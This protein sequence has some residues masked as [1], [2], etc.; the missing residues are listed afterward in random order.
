MAIPP[1]DTP[2]PRA[3]PAPAAK[4]PAANPAALS[5]TQKNAFDQVKAQ[6]DAYGL[7]SLS[8][9]VYNEIVAGKSSDEIARDLRG[10]PEFKARFPA[11][12]ARE[13]AGLPSLSPGEYVSYENQATQL[14]RAAG[15]P[16]GFYDQ[17]EDFTKLLAG[18]VSV[19]ELNDRIQ[20]AKTATYNLP[21]EA[22]ARLWHEYGL[23][24]GSG[25]LAAL[26]LDPQK[27]TPLLQ[28]DLAAAQIGGR[29]DMAGY[30]GLSDQAAQGLAQQGVTDAQAAAGFQN[31]THSQELFRALPGSGEN[32][33]S[34]QVQLGAAFGGNAEDQDV[35]E[36]RRRQRQAEFA[37]STSLATTA[38][39]VVGLAPADTP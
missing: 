37:G 10:T 15:L 5:T 38:K 39:G 34:Q 25:S 32:Q 3:T 30:V 4:P 19:S 9:F 1:D 26:F 2:R 12:A 17:P 33:I 18:D 6:L 7:G 27:A 21:P 8:T 16:P 31:L 22:Q 13:A 28:R 11:I 29:A 14:M 24:P 36:Q 23:A 20:D 35:I